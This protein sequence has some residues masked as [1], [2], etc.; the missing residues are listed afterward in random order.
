MIIIL[1]GNSIKHTFDII[2]AITILQWF[3]E[4]R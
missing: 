2:F 1:M 4:Y 3:V